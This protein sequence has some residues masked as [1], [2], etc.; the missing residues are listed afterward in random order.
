[1]AGKLGKGLAGAISAAADGFDDFTG[2]VTESAKADGVVT[3]SEQRTLDTLSRL[4]EAVT[5]TL[6]QNASDFVAEPSHKNHQVS[7][8]RVFGSRSCVI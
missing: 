8:I 1:M 4:N 5:H 7:V 2:R 3:P 6:S